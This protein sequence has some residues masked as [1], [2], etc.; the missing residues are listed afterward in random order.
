MSKDS[1]KRDFETW[2]HIKKGHAFLFHFLPFCLIS[3]LLFVLSLPRDDLLQRLVTALNRPNAECFS[4]LI[5]TFLLTTIYFAVISSEIRKACFL[6]EHLF[7]KTVITS[8]FYILVCAIIALNVLLAGDWACVSLGQYW[9]SFLLAILSLNGVGWPTSHSWINGI[10]VAV[11]NY[12]DAHWW[13]SVLLETIKDV[14]KNERGQL[15]D[16]IKVTDTIK[17][18]SD[19]LESNRSLEPNWEMD[20]IKDIGNSLDCFRGKLLSA[21]GDKTKAEPFASFCQGS[22][23]GDFESIDSSLKELG[24]LIPALKKLI[25]GETYHEFQTA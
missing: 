17:K 4:A 9:A 13:L 19:Q 2:F 24:R 6:A 18:L 1:I 10:G 12:T 11:P 21:F 3:L 25:Y 8:L 14:A 15:S 20:R 7:R 5:L 22:A 16:V 23:K